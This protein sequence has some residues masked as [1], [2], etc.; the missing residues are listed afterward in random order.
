[1][2]PVAPLLVTCHPPARYLTPNAF[3]AACFHIT[4]T[5]LL[6]DKAVVSI[7]FKPTYTHTEP[8]SFTVG[9]KWGHRR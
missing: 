4:D 2:R 3:I 1:M 6:E 5:K 8:C 9:E 7:A